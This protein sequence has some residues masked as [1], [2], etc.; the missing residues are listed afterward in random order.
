LILEFDFGFDF[1]VD[2]AAGSNSLFV[3]RHFL[4]WECKPQNI[5][6]AYLSRLRLDFVCFDRRYWLSCTPRQIMADRCLFGQSAFC[7]W[8]TSANMVVHVLSQSN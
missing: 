7:S 1:D 3:M 2:S 6:L 8:R 5:W 4:G